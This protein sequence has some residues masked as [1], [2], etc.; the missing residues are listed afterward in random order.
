MKLRCE[1]V[2]ETDQAFAANHFSLANTFNRLRGT[3][4]FFIE[5][6]PQFVIDFPASSIPIPSRL[7][8][9]DSP[10]RVLMVWLQ[11]GWSSRKNTQ[12]I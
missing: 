9:K 7:V 8:K 3:L 10:L 1:S 11:R 5:I 12:R 6:T 2:G 4:G